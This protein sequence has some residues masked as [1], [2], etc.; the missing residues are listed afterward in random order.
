MDNGQMNKWMELRSFKN[1]RE[2]LG[3]Q[4]HGGILLSKAL[5]SVPNTKKN[6]NGR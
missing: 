2:E 1:Q 5:G 4:H 3:V 6:L